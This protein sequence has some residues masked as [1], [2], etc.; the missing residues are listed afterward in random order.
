MSSEKDAF[1]QSIRI[2]CYREQNESIQGFDM[3]VFNTMQVFATI[4][5]ISIFPQ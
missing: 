5:K 4:D 2:P 3:E 1:S